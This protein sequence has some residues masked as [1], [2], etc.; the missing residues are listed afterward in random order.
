MQRELNI[1]Y[2]HVHS[3]AEMKSRDP[4]KLRPEWFSYESCFRNLISTIQNDPQ[5][6]FVKLIVMFDGD[7]TDFVDDFVSRYI[8]NKELNI[9][10]EFLE[11]G[12]DR[13]SGLIT[14]DYINR[15]SLPQGNLV[16]MLEN[17]YMHQPGWI[18]KVFELYNSDIAFDYLSLYDH[19]DKYILPMYKDL[20]A[21]IFHTQTHHW[22]TAP[23]SC[24]SFVSEISQF[25]SDYEIFRLGLPDFYFF[26]ALINKRK[27][28]LLTPI[29]GLSTHCM[30]GYMSPCLEWRN[31]IV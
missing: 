2:R 27:R 31:F 15:A 6:Q 11:A 14:L 4:N 13:N 19:R 16:Y 26:D 21:Q 22:R 9:G 7:H 24:G 18:S 10:L 25:R 12:S 28:V 23:S 8:A 20:I 17:D 30:E 1:Y 5:G 3:K 29:P